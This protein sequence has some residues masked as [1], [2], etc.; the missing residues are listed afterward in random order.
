M[1][2]L[3]ALVA[4]LAGGA[5]TA[6]GE[7]QRR[8][9]LAERQKERDA[10]A[11]KWE[12]TFAESKRQAGV[13]EADRTSR[14]RMNDSVLAVN[15][16]N[17]SDPNAPLTDVGS[18][19]YANLGQTPRQSVTLS[20]DPSV[21]PTL[22]GATVPDR[23]PLNAPSLSFARSGA[24]TASPFDKLDLG[25]G[26]R[27]APKL[28]STV[29]PGGAEGLRGDITT[30]RPLSAQERMQQ[31]LAAYAE[32]QMQGMDPNSPDYK[33]LMRVA[34]SAKGGKL[35]ALPSKT[36]PTV[37]EQ[38]LLDEIA[39]KP[40]ASIEELTPEQRV[41]FNER[42]GPTAAKTL[43]DFDQVALIKELGLPPD[44]NTWTNAQSK[45]YNERVIQKKKD[46]ANASR[47]MVIGKTDS[48]QPLPSHVKTA[49]Q[50]ATTNMPVSRKGPV[51]DTISRMWAEGDEEGV[52]SYVRQLAVEG[53]TVD[54]KNQVQG[55]ASAIDA[56]KDVSVLLKD[57][58]AA[59]VK[60]DKI[61]GTAENVMNWLGTT[62]D[63]KLV[64][65]RGRLE[66]IL[67]NFRRSMTGVAFGESESKAYSR[68]FPTFS[69]TLPVNQAQINGLRA[70]MEGN[71]RTFF[72]DKLGEAG[73]K[74]LEGKP[75]GADEYE[76][77][78]VSPGVWQVRKKGGG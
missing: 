39:G 22:R 14:N 15:A 6:Y 16:L 7:Y 18:A 60:T 30:T 23:A 10:E 38:A 17:D 48:M 41:V 5:E 8:Q 72:R 78:E 55:R 25:A 61:T 76:T 20:P 24:G 47:P 44:Q 63:P 70:S 43:P 62:T 31:D 27:P 36:M 51:N 32:Q 19:A 64:E 75:T 74:W 13:A 67:M 1:S 29:L 66:L 59:G 45:L 54:L 50:R 77:V 68:I 53:E 65:L 12:R 71:Q 46:I 52:K 49:V 34:F 2:A 56:L 57:L 3:Q 42:S 58:N 28:G 37:R 33:N 73:M 69:N 40:N 35:D 21:I 26:D 4:A 9:T 11:A